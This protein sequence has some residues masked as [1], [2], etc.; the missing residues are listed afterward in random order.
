MTSLSLF[1]V[2]TRLSVSK[3]SNLLV[4]T[5]TRVIRQNSLDWIVRS[6]NFSILFYGGQSVT[7]RHLQRKYV[8]DKL[9]D[10]KGMVGLGFWD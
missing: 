3:I 6:A 9:S 7:S 5:C 2:V 4:N 8:C 10:G 1:G